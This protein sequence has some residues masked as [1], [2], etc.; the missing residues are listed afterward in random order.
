[1]ERGKWTRAVLH[2]RRTLQ[3]LE[4]QTFY[5]KCNRGVRLYKISP[6]RKERGPDG[7]VLA[8]ETKYCARARGV[9]RVRRHQKGAGM[10]ERVYTVR[11]FST[12]FFVG[13]LIS[14]MLLCGMATLLPPAVRDGLNALLPFHSFHRPPI[15]VAELLGA[16]TGGLI[17]AVLVALRW[18]PSDRR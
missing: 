15:E 9:H 11:T 5:T 1:M 4:H 8:A 2:T 13:F 17:L 16:V 3:H 12:F 18:R 7:H 10:G 14:A 6:S